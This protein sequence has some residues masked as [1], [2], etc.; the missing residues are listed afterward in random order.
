MLPSSVFVVFWKEIR[1]CLSYIYYLV[2]TQ[3]KFKRCSLEVITTA[4]WLDCRNPWQYLQDLW[5]DYGQEKH[6]RINISQCE[7]SINHTLSTIS[8]TLKAAKSFFLW[9]WCI[10]S[11]LSWKTLRKRTYF[12]TKLAFVSFHKYSSNTHYT[13][14]PSWFGIVTFSYIMRSKKSVKCQTLLIGSFPTSPRENNLSSGGYGVQKII[15]FTN[16]THS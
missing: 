14:T 5:M 11:Y 7:W 16:F 3:M 1:Q 2:Q 13:V 9:I 15:N 12:R 10:R 8:A 6:S 4:W